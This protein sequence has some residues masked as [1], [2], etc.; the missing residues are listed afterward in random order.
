MTTP[1]I[2]DQDRGGT[3]DG[4]QQQRGRGQRLVAGAQNIGGANVAR[5]DAADVT[6]PGSAG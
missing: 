5:T 2:G 4:V 6:Q 1:P 3:L